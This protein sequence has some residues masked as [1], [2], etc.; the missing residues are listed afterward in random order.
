MPFYFD[1]VTIGKLS[2][3]GDFKIVYND[4]DFYELGNLYLYWGPTVNVSGS[5]LTDTW[6]A[7]DWS[8]YVPSSSNAIL[9]RIDHTNNSGSSSLIV[10]KPYWD[11]TT[12][13]ASAWVNGGTTSDLIQASGS[14][15]VR[16]TSIGPILCT[17]G[18]FYVA[19]YS[20][21]WPITSYQIVL[22]GYYSW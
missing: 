4:K 20:S 18:K 19:R 10:T 16:A 9:V 7:V 14:S 8:D 22:M 13:N 11:K 21:S 5:T 2:R 12:V 3:S 1:D 6:V 17:A 15:A